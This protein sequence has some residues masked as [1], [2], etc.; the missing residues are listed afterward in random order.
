MSQSQNSSGESLYLLDDATI[1]LFGLE[2]DTTE[3]EG[4]EREKEEE[5]AGA[6]E[7]VG[8][9]HNGGVRGGHNVDNDDDDDEK[10]RLVLEVEADPRF[11][12]NPRGIGC[13]R[14]WE[15]PYDIYMESPASNKDDDDDN[16]LHLRHT[17]GRPSPKNNKFGTW[18]SEYIDIGKGKRKGRMMLGGD[19]DDRYRVLLDGPAERLKYSAKRYALVRRR[20]CESHGWVSGFWV[21]WI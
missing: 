3:R 17:R 2:P 12:D 4:G 15:V 20:A 1:V 11:I 7:E 8:G 14:K 9:G 13:S 5:G 19:A 21:G 16:N 6:G 18:T 10:V